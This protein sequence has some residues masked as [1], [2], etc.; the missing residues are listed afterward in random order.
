MKRRRNF[1]VALSVVAVFI[2]IGSL[3]SV[4]SAEKNQE[5]TR[6][7]DRLF[8]EAQRLALR[9]DQLSAQLDALLADGGQSVYERIRAARFLG[10]LQYLPAIPTLIKYVDLMPPESSETLPPPAAESLA[11]YGDAA[12]PPVVRA[13]LAEEKPFTDRYW[14]LE[15]VLMYNLYGTR[16]GGPNIE[17]VRTYASGI[18]LMNTDQQTRRRIGDLLS[19]IN[20]LKKDK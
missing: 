12:I 7:Q 1:Y 9:R 8:E 20:T 19:S 18:I 13:Y 15:F 5:R 6:K 11:H 2:V 16:G 10:R 3:L 14:T 4:P 17:A